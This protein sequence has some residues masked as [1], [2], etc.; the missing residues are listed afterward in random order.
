MSGTSI[1][2]QNLQPVISSACK[3]LGS[4]G[5]IELMRVANPSLEQLEDHT[6][7]GSLCLIL[8]GWPGTKAKTAQRLRIEPGH[9]HTHTH[10][11][12]HKSQ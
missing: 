8:P 6:M 5:G 11:H 12:T 4:H 10:T 9:T 7:L 1:Q 3:T 2:P